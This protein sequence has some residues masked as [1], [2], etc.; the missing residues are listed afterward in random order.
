MISKRSYSALAAL[1]NKKRKFEEI[2]QTSDFALPKRRKLSE[3]LWIEKYS[4][5]TLVR[6]ISVQNFRMKW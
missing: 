1:K 5:K 6:L 3:D 4:P 2:S